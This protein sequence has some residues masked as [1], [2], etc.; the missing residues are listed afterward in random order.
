MDPSDIYLLVSELWKSVN[1]I[2]I[3]H[4][5]KN[6]I[7]SEIDSLNKVPIRFN[8]KIFKTNFKIL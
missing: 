1:N 6:D 4:I 3:F 5:H 2:D 7:K 8:L